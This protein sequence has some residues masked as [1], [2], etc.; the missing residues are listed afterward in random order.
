MAYRVRASFLPGRERHGRRQARRPAAARHRP[1]A[2][3][4][5]W[6][7]AASTSCRCSRAWRCRT[8]LAAATN[9]KSSTG[10]LDVFTRVIADGVAAFDQIPAG[11]EGPLYAEIC[12]QTFPIVVRKGSRLSARSASASAPAR[13]ATWRWSSCNSARSSSPP[14]RP[15]SP[16]GIALSVDLVG[17]QERPRRLSRQAAHRPRRCRRAGRLRACVDFWEPIT[18]D[19]SEAAD[20]RSR[21]VLHPG[22]QGGR[23]RAAD[24]RRRDGAVQS[25]GRRVPR[26]LRGL[27]RSGLRPRRGR[28]HRRQ[29]G[30]GGAQPQGA[31]HP[32]GRADRRPPHL[33][34]ADR[35]ARDALRPRPRLATTRARASSSPSISSS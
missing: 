35:G 16:R 9:P 28:R 13:T 15:T 29:G 10:R 30:A 20:P 8:H 19:G 27:L 1:D 31:V 25:A 2:R 26:A 3:A 12:P 34:A 7:R 23:A 4:P 5:C 33:R 14:S 11:Y 6:R 21:P 32:G 22:L 18:R 17:R 24:A